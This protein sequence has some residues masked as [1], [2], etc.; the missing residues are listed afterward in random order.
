M[1]RP[2]CARS[3]RRRPRARAA[4]TA[5]PTRRTARTL[6]P[7][8]LED[9]P[10]PLDSSSS[11]RRSQIDWPRTCLRHHHATNRRRRRPRCHRSCDLRSRDRWSRSRIVTLGRGGSRSLN[12]SRGSF[13]GRCSGRRGHCRCGGDWRCGPYRSR[14][15]RWRCRRSHVRPLDRWRCRDARGWLLRRR[16][17]T[18]RRNHHH[19]RSRNYRSD[20]RPACNRW[21]RRRGN[22]D[23]RLLSGQRHDPPRRRSSRSRA[24]RCADRCPDRSASLD[25]RPCCRRCNVSRWRRSHSWRARTR[26][27]ATRLR[28]GLPACQNRLHCVAR[29]GDIREIE[30]RPVL[31]RLPACRAAATP[32]LEVVAHPFRLIGLDRTGVR[33]TLGHAN[34]CQSVQNG[35]ALDFQFPCEI[36]N[37]NFAHPSLFISPARLAV[38]IS[39][40]EVGM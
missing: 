4:R 38:H 10:S 12:R 32:V 17:R 9:R 33:L 29:L 5:R 22:H 23:R 40:I 7:R 34:R 1:H 16:L 30:L 19:R 2:P 27:Q 21:S 39:L 36:V 3:H 25:H 18:S 13:A 35:P 20:R 6:W 15:Y 14:S 24:A 37:S 8:T 31:R 11:P 26:R 28:F